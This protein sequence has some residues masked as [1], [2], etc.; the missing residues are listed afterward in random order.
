MTL[1]V[2]CTHY[3]TTITQKRGIVYRVMEYSIKL[4]LDAARLTAANPEAFICLPPVERADI[5]L[6]LWSDSW[7]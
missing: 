5:P 7:R 6:Q 1:R 2:E 4:A 3:S